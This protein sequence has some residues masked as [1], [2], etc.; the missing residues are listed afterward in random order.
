VRPTGS[1]SKVSHCVL[2]R[3]RPGVQGPV[4]ARAGPA[5]P[6]GRAAGSEQ[7]RAL[8]QLDCPGPA[9]Q[10]AFA[11]APAWAGP[12][13]CHGESVERSEP[14]YSGQAYMHLAPVRH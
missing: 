1:L 5:R 6:G 11:V 13:P 10:A 9:G 2:A 12:D 14:R 4:T 8:R 7:W 3:G